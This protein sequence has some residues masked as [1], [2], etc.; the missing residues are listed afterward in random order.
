MQLK[1]MQTF[2]V[3]HFLQRNVI[4]LKFRETIERFQKHPHEGSKLVC[5]F[6]L[7]FICLHTLRSHLRFT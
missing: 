3:S 7:T 4:L 2:L 6:H 5:A 1:Q